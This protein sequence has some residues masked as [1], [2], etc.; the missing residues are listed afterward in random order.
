[1]ELHEHLAEFEELEMSF[2]GHI[3]N[4]NASARVIEAAFAPTTR[5]KNLSS[6][7]AGGNQVEIRIALVSFLSSH[8]VVLLIPHSAVC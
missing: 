7:A 3:N 4:W 2:S 1:M 8:C 5:S 6:Q